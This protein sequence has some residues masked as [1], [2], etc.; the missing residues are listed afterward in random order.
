MLQTVQQLARLMATAWPDNPVA[1]QLER[2]AAAAL[3]DHLSQSC[4]AS[5][6]TPAMPGHPSKQSF[7]GNPDG[8]DPGGSDD[9]RRR[10]ANPRKEAA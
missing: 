3:A 8:A 2:A 4:E 6:G 1:G 9:R 5:R 7:D 10:R